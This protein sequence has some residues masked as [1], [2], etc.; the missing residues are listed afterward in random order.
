MNVGSVISVSIPISF[1]RNRGYGFVM[2]SNEESANKCI[3]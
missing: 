1:G 2:M 3:K